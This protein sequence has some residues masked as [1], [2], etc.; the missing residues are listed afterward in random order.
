VLVPVV[1]VLVVPVVVLVV[2]LVV[3]RFVLLGVGG[4]AA[5]VLSRRTHDRQSAAGTDG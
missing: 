3:V 5:G 2:V 1:V 4:S